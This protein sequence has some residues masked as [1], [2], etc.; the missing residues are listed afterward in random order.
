V[1]L[2]RGRGLQMHCFRDRHSPFARRTKLAKIGESFAEKTRS[3]FCQRHR[4]R[5]MVVRHLSATTTA[6]RRR[7]QSVSL[8]RESI[9]LCVCRVDLARRARWVGGLPPFLSMH[10]VGRAGRPLRLAT[11]RD[12]RRRTAHMPAHATYY[13]QRAAATTYVRPLCWTGLAGIKSSMQ[14]Y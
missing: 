6:T 13:F 14:P 2:W 10:V 1:A 11:G 4:L 3:Y 5:R 7:R 12:E 9:G 8:R